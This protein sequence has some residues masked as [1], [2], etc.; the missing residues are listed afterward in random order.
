MKGPLNS[1]EPHGDWAPGLQ[2]ARLYEAILMDIIL[3]ELPP[4]RVLEEKTLAARYAG[5]VAGIRDALGRLALEGLV[6]RR[7]R[8]G[9]IVAPLDIAEIEHAF[10]VRRML[11]GRTAALAARNHRPEDLAA[12]TGAFDNAEAS[13]AAGD[14]RA[15]LAMDHAFHRAVAFATHNPTL[16]RFVIALQNVAT[17]FWIW[18]MEKQSPE[19]QLKDVMLHRAMA[20]A[21]AEGDPI[22]AEATCALLIGEPP[23]AARG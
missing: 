15:M 8:V 13:I 7:P 6:V 3:G 9:T 1:V 11:E 21:I 10:E 23:S 12:I 16:A 22:A 2:K 18:Q 17:R 14:L 20:Q 4:M 5:G 19:D